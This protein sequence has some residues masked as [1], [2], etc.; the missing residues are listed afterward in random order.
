MKKTN[1]IFLLFLL[2]GFLQSIHGQNL[3]IDLENILENNPDYTKI[4]KIKE[5]KF[6]TNQTYYSENSI[7]IQE[8]KLPNGDVVKVYSEPLRP[9][10]DIKKIQH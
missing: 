6:D 7:F 10:R 1:F 3:T 2:F 9:K 5:V 4:P 8:T